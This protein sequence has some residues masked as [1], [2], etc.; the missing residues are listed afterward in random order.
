MV[1][2]PM[3]LRVWDI[4]AQ[5]SAYHMQK[6]TANKDSSKMTEVPNK[7]DAKRWH[8]A[9]PV[10]NKT[11]HRAGNFLLHSK[12]LEVRWNLLGKVAAVW[13]WHGFP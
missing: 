1:I 5:A 6:H 2:L 4:C 10:T 3:Y 13:D 12:G 8:D 11:R 9:L 7:G